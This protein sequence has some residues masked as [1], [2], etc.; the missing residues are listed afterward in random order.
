MTLVRVT[1]KST[2]ICISIK[3]MDYLPHLLPGN[4]GKREEEATGG[5]EVDTSF[6]KIWGRPDGSVA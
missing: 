1:A 5:E 4:G 3:P 2:K 6:K